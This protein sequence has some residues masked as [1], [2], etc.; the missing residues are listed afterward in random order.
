MH[1]YGGRS[2]DEEI[3]DTIKYLYCTDLFDYI[4]LRNLPTSLEVLRINSNFNPRYYTINE[5][6]TLCS[7]LDNLPVSLNKIEM[8][9][10]YEKY[11]DLIKLP[12]DTELVFI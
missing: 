2:N 9:K 1:I 12:Y 7:H 10:C 6:R 3:Y 8:S 11:I 5:S 4:F